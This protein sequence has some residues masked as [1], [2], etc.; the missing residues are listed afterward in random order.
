MYWSYSMYW[1]SAMDGSSD[2]G[3]SCQ[4]SSGPLV[5]GRVVVAMLLEWYGTSWSP[6]NCGSSGWACRTCLRMHDQPGK[7]KVEKKRRLTRR[8]DGG[9]RE[10][11]E[12]VR[13]T[14]MKMHDRIADPLSSQTTSIDGARR[15]APSGQAIRGTMAV[16]GMDYPISRGNPPPLPPCVKLSLVPL[17]CTTSI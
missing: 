9:V 6:T 15:L 14:M 17:G 4:W 1:S 7:E 11:S 2:T 3:T 5:R 13:V 8:P 16:E 10:A 12:G